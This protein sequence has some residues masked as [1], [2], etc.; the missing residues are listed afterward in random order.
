MEAA[1]RD[2]ERAET[3]SNER[4]HKVPIAATYAKKATVLALCGAPE[5]ALEAL[6]VAV[7][8]HDE[9][10]GQEPTLIRETEKA[11]SVLGIA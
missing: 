5:E 9:L 4:D 8:L 3:Q 6:S 7:H 1:L 11:K 2:I 10:G